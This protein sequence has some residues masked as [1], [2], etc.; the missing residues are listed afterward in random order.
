M[1]PYGPHY[2][3]LHCKEILGLDDV[4]T[5]YGTGLKPIS[6]WAEL[7]FSRRRSIWPVDSFTYKYKTH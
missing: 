1:W 6:I 7:G 5:G 4:A 3:G 2:G